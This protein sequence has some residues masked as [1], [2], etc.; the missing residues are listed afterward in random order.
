MLVTSDPSLTVEI[1]AAIDSI[2]GL[3]LEVVADEIQARDRLSTGSFALLLVHQ[4]G[5]RDRAELIRPARKASRLVET[6]VIDEGRGDRRAEALFEVGV[7]ERLTRPID[8]KRLAYLLE[9]RGREAPHGLG[10]NLDGIPSIEGTIARLDATLL[11]TGEPGTGKT[12]LARRIHGL[13]TRRDRPFLSV[14]LLEISARSIE[15]AAFGHARGAFP[16]ADR[17]RVGAFAEVDDGTLVL[18]EIGSLPMSLQVKVLRAIEDRAFEP[19]GSDIPLPVKARLIVT[20]RMPLETE[21]A[22][23]RFR[24]D[25]FYRLNVLSMRLP[26]LRERGDAI[27]GLA[28]KFL[29]E[30]AGLGYGPAREFSPDSMRAFM[31]YPWPGNIRELRETIERAI[32]RSRGEIIPIE[33]LPATVR[34]NH[35]PS[36]SARS[37]SAARGRVPDSLTLLRQDSERRKIELALANHRNNRLRTARELGI[38]RVTLYRK[39]QKY[40]I[41]ADP[42]RIDAKGPGQAGD[43]P[44]FAPDCG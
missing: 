4:D 41:Q 9:I 32:R 24:A 5:D 25:L 7:A 43:N 26:P 42:A 3:A 31:S 33:D 39:L 14:D 20:N 34:K 13:S 10:F 16:E 35:Q 22:E 21:V 15:S 1:G 8:R 37:R 11:L 38:S 12:W 17:D 6:I 23:G 19:I 40:G 27:P 18:D 28:R 36:R 30:F 44:E 29:E 2:G